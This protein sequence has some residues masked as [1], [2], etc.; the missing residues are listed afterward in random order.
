MTTKV[1]QNRQYTTQSSKRYNDLIL[2][3][4]HYMLTSE[5]I[6]G[7][8][9][10][11]NRCVSHRIK[12]DKKEKNTNPQQWEYVKKDQ[13][14][15]SRQKERFFFPKENDQLF[16]LFYLLQNGDTKYEII[17]TSKFLT[18]KEEKMKCIDILR[19]NKK[20]LSTYKI[21]GLKDTVEDDLVNSK[22]IDI[23]TFFALCITHNMNIMYI[24]KQKYYEL[25]CDPDDN[26]LP[27]VVHRI[28]TPSL[29][30]GYELNMTQE[31]IDKY[32]KTYYSSYSLSSPLKCASSYKV[33][34]LKDICKQVQI[35]EDI[36]SNKTKPQLY[37]LLIDTL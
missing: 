18:E 1:F 22:K 13:S 7:M 21:K 35:E 6:T 17:D 10:L 12:E 27:I 29:K 2:G 15:M 4:N 16:W 23:K 36:I 5:V 30:Y 20:Q 9:E 33:G 19:M 37:Q 24:H 8:D 14:M 32:R 26:N 3:M 25:N 11:L 34:E 31:K 28:D